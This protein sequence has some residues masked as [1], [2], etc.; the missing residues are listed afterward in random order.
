[1]MVWSLALDSASSVIA[2]VSQVMEPEAVERTLQ[3]AAHPVGRIASAEEV[4][5][6]Y[7]YMAT[8]QASFFTGPSSGWMAATR[9]SRET[10]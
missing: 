5:S 6:V 2:L 10:Q 9:L 7:A 8:D 1:M 3:A 4:A